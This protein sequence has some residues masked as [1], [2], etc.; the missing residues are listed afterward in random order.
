MDWAND[1]L[2]GKVMPHIA[3][4]LEVGRYMLSEPAAPKPMD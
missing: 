1:A 4:G 3:G 2:S